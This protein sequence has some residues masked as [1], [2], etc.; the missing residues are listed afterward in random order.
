M[1]VSRSGIIKIESSLF[2]SSSGFSSIVAGSSLV[3]EMSKTPGNDGL[4][5]SVGQSTNGFGSLLDGEPS[6]GV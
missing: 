4:L 1:L 3:L 5:L 2:N 6:F